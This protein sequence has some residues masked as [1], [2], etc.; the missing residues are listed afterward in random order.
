M[1]IYQ[2]FHFPWKR[3]IVNGNLLVLGEKSMELAL[4][5]LRGPQPT[6]SVSQEGVILRS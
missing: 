1:E 3:N 4:G 5:S 6:F 2:E